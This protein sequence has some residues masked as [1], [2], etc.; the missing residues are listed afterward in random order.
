M[1]LDDDGKELAEELGKHA[2]YSHHDVT[3]EAEWDAVVAA[4]TS[5][6]GRLDVLV[7]N[8]GVFL[9]KSMAKTSLEDYMRVVTIN[10]VGNFLGLKAV[11]QTMMNQGSGSIVNISSTSGL[12]GSPGT[13][14]Y[15]ASKFA[16]RGMTKVAAA[17]L[18]QF[19]VRV[20]SVH[21]GIVDDTTMATQVRR[22]FGDE[23]VEALK[24]RI[25]SGRFAAVDEVARMVVYLASDE[26]SY[27]TGSEFVVDGGY[28]AV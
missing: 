27:S 26:S 2:G 4:A 16:I 12:T 23:P 24:A 11:M 1:F 17:E 8:A 5:Q 20:N 14:A 9:V 7:N 13:I 3:S 25:P 21:P 28:T 19:G 22:A 15:A 18:A 6:F 10:Q